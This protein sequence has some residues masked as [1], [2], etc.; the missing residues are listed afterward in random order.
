ME[1]SERTGMIVS[2]VAHIGAILWLMLGGIFFS[3]DLPPPVE[4]AEV[5]LM[6][7]AE[8]AALQRRSADR[9]GRER[10]PSPRCP[11]PRR[12]RKPRPRPNRRPSPNLRARRARAAARTRHRAGCDRTDPARAGGG[13]HGPDIAEP[14]FEVPVETVLPEPQPEPKAAPR[15]APIRPK[16][17]TK[18]PIPRP[19]RWPR[20]HRSPPRNRCPEP[21]RRSRRAA[22][23]RSGAGNRGQQGPDRACLGGA[24]ILAASE[25]APGKTRTRTRAGTGGGAGA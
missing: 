12:S 19:R 2:G 11:N 7:E 3:H 14:A 1:R 17:R 4:T 20:P 10:R 22:R 21:A 23:K 18:M 25:T 24:R 9:A 5:S 8:F 16:R 15:V 6:S 13:G